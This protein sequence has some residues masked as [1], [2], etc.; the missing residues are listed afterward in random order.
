MSQNYTFNELLRL[1]PQYAQ[2]NDPLFLESVPNFI[3]LAENKLATEMKQQGFQAVVNG[4]FPAGNVMQKPAFWRE[5]ISFE[6]LVNGEWQ[7]IYLRSLEWCKQYWPIQ[8]NTGLPKYYADYNI[9]HFY[10]A[11]TPPSPFQ[12]QLVYFARLQPLTEENQTNWM[13]LNAPQA[14]FAACMYQASLF[15]KNGTD[16]AMWDNEYKTALG[17]LLNENRDR[18]AERDSLVKPQ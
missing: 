6:Y 12:F 5:T 11:P 8:A 18:W 7:S 13:T 1:I 14:L 3:A 9:S 16:I 2:R 15:K 10:I 17:S 4:N